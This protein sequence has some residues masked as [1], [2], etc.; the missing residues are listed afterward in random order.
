MCVQSKTTAAEQEQELS[1]NIRLLYCSDTCLYLPG[2]I[3]TNY[4]PSISPLYI[5][6]CVI[7]NIAAL[8]P[9]REAPSDF[10]GH[11]F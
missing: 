10:A 2:Q 4:F 8:R 9:A 3:S 11:Q 5:P 1:R 6:L 7:V